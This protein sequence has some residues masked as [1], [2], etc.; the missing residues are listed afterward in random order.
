MNELPKDVGIALAQLRLDSRK[1]QAEIA[2][3]LQTDQSRVSR[4]EK[5]EVAPTVAEVRSY[6]KAIK[7]PEANSFLRFLDTQWKFF[8]QPDAVKNPQIDVLQQIEELA[9]S[10]DSFERTHDL[11]AALRAEVHMHLQS[12]RRAFDYLSDLRHDV[13]FLGD[14]GVGKT[15][16]LCFIADLVLPNLTDSLMQ[17]V[18]LEVGGG[19][20]TLCE[21]RIQKGPALGLIIE[22][23][24][25]SEI[26]TAISDF[27][28]GVY[29]AAFDPESQQQELKKG[30]SEELERAIRNMSELT[31][32]SVKDSS[33]SRTT[34]DPALD[35]AKELKGLD[36]LRSAVTSRLKL[37][38]RTQTEIWYEGPSNQQ[39]QLKWLRETFTK[40]NNG[41]LPTVSLPRRIDVLK[42][43]PLV[44][45]SQFEITF[46]DTKGVD[47]TA[48]RPDL[49]SRL[50]DPRTLTV[51]CSTFNNAPDPTMLR[52]IEQAIQTGSERV[53]PERVLLFVLS[54]PGEAL[55]MKYDNGQNVESDQEGY[56]LK[57]EQVE[58]ALSR[59]GAG[60]IPI[61]FFNV[62]S[63][64]ANASAAKLSDSLA[65]MRQIWVDRV[66]SLDKT[67]GQ[68][69]KNHKIE[70]VILVRKE[71]T[72][73]LKIF[74]HNQKLRAQVRPP[75]QEA[76]TAFE[77]LNA[78]TVWASTRRRGTFRNLDIYY[79]LGS[80]A[81]SE[82]KRRSQ[83][84]LN[85]LEALLQNMLCDP[86]LTS[87]YEFLQEVRTNAL[88]WQKD[89]IEAVELAGAETY[90]PALNDDD[91]LWFTCEQRWGG[92]P[93][94]RVDVASYIRGWFETTDRDELHS[95]L[96]AKIIGGWQTFVVNRLAALCE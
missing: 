65:R 34:I 5:A 28:A 81:A 91:T 45:N 82:A 15:T 76:I 9:Q 26:Y 72:R 18:A 1:T 77:T 70:A 66:R 41:R 32:K 75:H 84:T 51:I 80:G 4:I 35:L 8:R 59:I 36:Q 16:A 88:Q 14:I 74:L 52:F 71:V 87:A 63:D 93:G 17:R 60:G 68:L 64:D 85:D 24:S 40:V 27:C 73:R 2:Q 25:D 13:A 90:R 31:R 42:P 79:Y 86:E 19:R 39:S 69:I 47:E 95:A 96:E 20:T 89:F 37:K 30:V 46:I 21:V 7:S 6:L 29:S 83:A 57:L 61:R 94:Y 78:R 55:T 54:R 50:D 67:I 38:E 11:A 33:G 58:N 12:L 43:D 62:A 53:F 92:G 56:D 3:R 44:R 49:K 23:Q 10:L 22:P 48:L